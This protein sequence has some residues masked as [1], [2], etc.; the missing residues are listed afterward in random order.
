VTE[1]R[2]SNYNQNQS[3]NPT[4]IPSHCCTSSG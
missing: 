3:R 4:T 2:L 1:N